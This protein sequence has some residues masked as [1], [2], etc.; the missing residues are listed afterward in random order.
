M[1]APLSSLVVDQLF[2]HILA[3]VA[4]DC[5]GVVLHEDGSWTPSST[6]PRDDGA[7]TS[8]TP[9]TARS[10]TS[11]SGSSSSE[12]AGRLPQAADRSH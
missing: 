4:G 12:P 3:N 11:P 10:S 1:R 7:A 9:S 5:D 2:A 6:S 8:V